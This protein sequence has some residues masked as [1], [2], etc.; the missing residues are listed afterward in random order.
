M[1]FSS[2]FCFINLSLAEIDGTRSVLI[3]LLTIQVLINMIITL[4]QDHSSP[5]SISNPISR[6]ICLL[7]IRTSFQ[8]STPSTPMITALDHSPSRFIS[9]FLSDCSFCKNDGRRV[10]KEKPKRYYSCCFEFDLLNQS[11]VVQYDPTNNIGMS[12]KTSSIKFPVYC[13]ERGET[14]VENAV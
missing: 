1:D 11:S 9:P 13:R 2:H 8:V 7:Q 3:W 14:S 6:Y 5:F 10:F 4:N 12:K